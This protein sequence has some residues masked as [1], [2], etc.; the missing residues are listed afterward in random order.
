MTQAPSTEARFGEVWWLCRGMWTAHV[1]CC[2]RKVSIWIIW[3]FQQHYLDHVATITVEPQS[4]RNASASVHE[5]D[6][7]LKHTGQSL[8]A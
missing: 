4:K 8:L 2:V 5:A 1:S 7:E 3:G 6:E